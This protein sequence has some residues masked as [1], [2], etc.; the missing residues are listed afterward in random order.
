MYS[1][2]GSPLNPAGGASLTCSFTKSFSGRNAHQAATKAGIPTT[3]SINFV[4]VLNPFLISLITFLLMFVRRAKQGQPVPAP[5]TVFLKLL[6]RRSAEVGAETLA[7]N[8]YRSELVQ[9]GSGGN[10][11]VLIALVALQASEFHFVR[12][13][14]H[15][16]S[17]IG[18][19]GGRDQDDVHIRTIG[20]A[21]SGEAQHQLSFG[22]LI[23]RCA[24]FGLVYF[25]VEFSG[26]HCFGLG[27]MHHAVL[28][29]AMFHFVLFHCFLFQGILR[30]R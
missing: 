4:F 28:L 15:E 29:H 2:S 10:F 18:G 24:A 22:F 3:A 20:S 25:A 27:V 23:Y 30:T 13:A 12:V 7:V 9:I 17:V 14:L 6:Q 11:V 26:G 16:V 8:G 19:V 21:E 5:V 1:A